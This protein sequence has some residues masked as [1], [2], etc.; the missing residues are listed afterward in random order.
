M[1]TV[2]QFRDTHNLSES[3]FKRLVER[4]M[5]GHNLTDRTAIVKRHGSNVYEVVDPGLLEQY[6]PAKPSI[7]SGSSHTPTALALPVF[8]VPTVEIESQDK[9][10]RWVSTLAKS[11]A[12]H[13]TEHVQTMQSAD[14]HIAHIQR[15]RQDIDTHLH[16]EELREFEAFEKSAEAKAELK[17][18]VERKAELQARGKS[19]THLQ[20]R[21]VQLR[22]FLGV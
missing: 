17:L 10:G 20:E 21:I 12:A 11:G 8:N 22:S 2:K 9:D 5:D 1:L 13:L 6:L 16:N 19:S 18:L 4:A 14:A 15:F 7:Q 3:G